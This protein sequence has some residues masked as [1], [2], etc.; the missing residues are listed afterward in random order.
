MLG[1]YEKNVNG[2][3]NDRYSRPTSQCLTCMDT[4]LTDPIA[5]DMLTDIFTFLAEAK[6]PGVY[7]ATVHATVPKLLPMLSHT[8]P[9]IITSTVRILTALFDG[10]KPGE[11]GDGVVHAL[12][13]NLFALLQSTKDRD[14]ISVSNHLR[15]LAPSS[16]SEVSSTGRDS[17]PRHYHPKRHGPTNQVD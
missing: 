8:D 15:F 1:T 5:L 10:A 9:W 12:G 6:A 13:H 7:A 14:T 3:L 16:D 4:L 11:L 17:A 2:A